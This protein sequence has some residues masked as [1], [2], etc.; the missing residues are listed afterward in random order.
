M[1]IIVTPRCYRR[2]VDGNLSRELELQVVRARM[3]SVATP[4]RLVEGSPGPVAATTDS[5]GVHGAT[6]HFR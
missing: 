2:R 4:A 1:P 6:P 5:E 3:D